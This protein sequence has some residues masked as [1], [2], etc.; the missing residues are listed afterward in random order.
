MDHAS[1]ELLAGAALAAD[2]DR[3]HR[4]RN[5]AHEIEHAPRGRRIAD[6]D[7]SRGAPAGRVEQTAVLLLE[8][9]ALARQL[10]EVAAVLDRHAAEA[11]QGGQE[12]AVLLVEL[13]AAAPALPVRQ[14]EHAERTAARADGDSDRGGH[15]NPEELDV[16][17]EHRRLGSGHLVQEGVIR[18][19]RIGNRLRKSHPRFGPAF[20]AV[21]ERRD[22]AASRVEDADGAPEHVFDQRVL[23]RQRSESPARV[24]K[25]FEQ[26][27]LLLDGEFARRL[28]EI[29]EPREPFVA[30]SRR[31]GFRLR[32]A[33]EMHRDLPHA[34][35]PRGKK[36]GGSRPGRPVRR[37]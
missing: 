3:R 37:H 1:H 15:G 19:G 9:L 33:L 27:E 30:F 28:L 26:E 5:A 8:P 31:A 22:V 21:R 14:H 24:I 2:Q 10:L 34:T 36:S 11:R 29:D 18:H 6:E 7:A 25:R 12:T 13:H 4:G 20:P 17:N 35:P 32:S 16:L 23:V